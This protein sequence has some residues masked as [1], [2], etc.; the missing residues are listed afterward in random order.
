[1]TERVTSIASK[2]ELAR[3]ARVLQREGLKNVTPLQLITASK[4]YDTLVRAE[5]AAAKLG[6]A[7]PAR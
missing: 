5:T 7:A 4:I 3:A 2:Q 6:V 1:M